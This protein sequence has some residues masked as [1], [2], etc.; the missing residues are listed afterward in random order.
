MLKILTGK[1]GQFRFCPSMDRRGHRLA[2]KQTHLAEYFSHP[3]LGKGLAVITD[4]SDLTLKQ[5][6]QICAGITLF[7]NDLVLAILFQL[8]QCGQI[9]QGIIIKGLKNFHA[10]QQIKKTIHVLHPLPT[11]RRSEQFH[12]QGGKFLF[13]LEL[14]TDHA[15]TTTTIKLGLLNAL[16]GE[17]LKTLLFSG[18]RDNGL[19]HLQT[20][21]FGLGN[22]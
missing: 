5:N 14:K 17:A 15:V 10:A 22:R 7:Q 12:L 21:G 9:T 6:I 19:H 11:L 8:E 18:C 20:G 13:L 3:H 16:L 4:N 1:G 2:G